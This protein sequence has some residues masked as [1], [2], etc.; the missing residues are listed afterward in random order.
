ML[1]TDKGGDFEM[2][3][4]GSY[5][6]TCKSVIDIGTQAS[7][8]KGQAK[9]T[10]KIIIGWELSE[11]MED[12]QPFV[13]NQFY[14]ASLNEKSTLR[15]HLDAWR[16]RTFTADELGGFDPSKLIGAPCLLTLAE[17]QQGKVKVVGVSKI[18]K[19]LKSPELINPKVYFSLEAGQIDWIVFD[20][21]S[22]GLKDLIRKSPEYVQRLQEKAGLTSKEKENIETS[23]GFD[24]VDDDIPF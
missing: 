4:A 5:V 10:R 6:A 21:F 20:S 9:I 7:E 15:K 8:Y 1:L 18:P 11:K 12:G 23:Y 17:N 22:D 16:G 14:T 3:D 13:M 24:D 19:E 2:P